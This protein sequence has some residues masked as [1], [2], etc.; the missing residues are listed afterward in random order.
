VGQLAKSWQVSP[1]QLEWTFLLRDDV[2]WH[3]GQPFTADD[4]KF[5]FETIAFN[6]NCPGPKFADFPLLIG[7]DLLG[8]HSIKFTLAAPFAPFLGSLTQGIVP[9][10]IFDP[11]IAKGPDK[12]SIAAMEKHPRNW[13]PIGTGPYILAH[14]VDN[15]Y[16]TLERNGNYYDGLYPYI[17]TINLKFFP[18]L[19]SA[20]DALQAGEVDLLGDIPE[21]ALQELETS[22]GASHNFYFSQELGYHFLCFNF[23]PQA[24]GPDRVNPWLDIRVRQAVAHA[25]NRENF[26]DEQ[27]YGRG[28][29]M[30]SPVPPTSWAFAPALANQLLDG[31]GWVRAPGGWRHKGGQKL[32]FQLTTRGDNDFH[33]AIAAMVQ[34]EL[35]E[36]G[37]EVEL[38]TVPWNEMLGNHVLSGDFE[39]ML[40]GLSL[41][42]DPDAFKVFHTTEGLNFGAYSNE[43]LDS[44]LIQGRE[45]ADIQARKEIYGD[46]QAILAAD[47]P[48]IFLFSREMTAAA[49]GHIRGIT[50]SALG[51]CWPERWSIEE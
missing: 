34:A 28:V 38:N 6:E 3:D 44:L 45:T 26:L 18:D 14:W 35:G 16:I 47:L 20:L 49:A 17:E 39:M 29:L 36:I 24:F 23:R 4:V 31:A 40:M 42:P 15:E 2:Y 37:I 33:L 32:S 19:I 11:T 1:D 22:L 7:I 50:V 25:L 8:E 27:L 48:Y 10:H 21:D 5:T 43:E 13:K 12:V 9:R 46:M 51:L 30:N 41:T